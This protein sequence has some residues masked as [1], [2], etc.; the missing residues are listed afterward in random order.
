MATELRA[1]RSVLAHLKS[2]T[3]VMGPALRL[4]VYL[5]VLC[6]V[7][8]SMIPAVRFNQVVSE[9]PF[10]V[11]VWVLQILAVV[12]LTHFPSILPVRHQVKY[13]GGAA[14]WFGR[15][16]ESPAP[17]LVWMAWVVGGAMTGQ[18]GMMVLAGAGVALSLGVAY[19]AIRA[20]DM[21]AVQANTQVIANPALNL[22]PLRTQSARFIYFLRVLL[23]LG[24]GA[25]VVGSVA[26]GS[27]VQAVLLLAISCAI[28]AATIGFFGVVQERAIARSGAHDAARQVKVAQQVHPAAV[29]V[30]YSQPGKS[31]DLA[32]KNLSK[33]L[34]GE[35]LITALISRETSVHKRFQ[36]VDA[37]YFWPAPTIA[38]LD[39]Y[40]LETLRA[41]FYTNDAIKNGHFI[42]FSQFIHVLVTE[43]SRLE[44]AAA[45]PH[46]LAIYDAI[47][48][49]N[50]RTA[51]RWRAVASPEI[52]CRIMTVGKLNVNATLL[53]AIRRCSDDVVIS[54]HV[55][56]ED[57]KEATFGALMDGLLAVFA[58]VMVLPEV[59]LMLSYTS[60]RPSRLLD[61]LVAEFTRQAAVINGTDPKVPKRIFLREG[62]AEAFHNA[63]DVLIAT[64]EVNVSEM[65][66]TQKLV[67]WLG[68]G[69]AARRCVGDR[70]GWSCLWHP[71]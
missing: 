17:F 40:A 69:H 50:F 34:R 42:R 26:L 21:I 9:I 10:D 38:H 41:I 16:P 71:T 6:A 46:G 7:V 12:V 57:L 2:G 19:G 45:L 48:A 63:A 64:G 31:K 14:K 30:H 24:S 58:D 37:D 43:F 56:S 27:S 66:E 33:N 47:V 4:T 68:G 61:L 35:G 60:D 53:P 8:A 25:A 1:K 5:V 39:A 11:L 65:L 13:M 20:V 29:A 67:F 15:Y 22:A 44:R 36:P 55:R 59:S 51:Q 28:G 54:V 32:P 23:V 52:A 49:P 62:R 18:T 70:T 3:P